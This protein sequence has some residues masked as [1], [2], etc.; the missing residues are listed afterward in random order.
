MME[1]YGPNDIEVL[2]FLAKVSR[3]TV[4]QARELVRLRARQ[5]P[6]SLERAGWAA[7]RAA[8]M[9]GRADALE[10]ARDAIR[11]W[12]RFRTGIP[13]FGRAIRVYWRRPPKGHYEAMADAVPG[14]LDAISALV[15]RDVLEPGAFAVL[16]DPWLGAQQI[17]ASESHRG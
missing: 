6:D 5:E 9:V 16:H 4:D 15:V 12:R 2:G 1:G 3:L 8:L 11:A 10:G 13:W 7:E 14:L 17:A